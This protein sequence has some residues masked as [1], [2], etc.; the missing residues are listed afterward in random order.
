M[1]VHLLNKKR[2][3]ALLIA[4]CCGWGTAWASYSFS[5]T[6]SGKTLY[7]NIVSGTNVE[8]CYPGTL[9]TS[10]SCGWDGYT[11]PTGAVSIPSTVTNNGTTYSVKY[12]GN[13]AFAGCTGITSVSIPS[14]IICRASDGY[15]NTGMSGKGM[16]FKNCSGLTSITLPNS[17]TFTCLPYQMCSMCT[18]LSSI[19]IPS[20]ITDIGPDCFVNTAL[21]SVTIPSSV[22]TIYG[23]ALTY[24]QNLSSITVQASTPPTLYGYSQFDQNASSLVIYVPCESRDTYR[25]AWSSYSS[26]IQGYG[27]PYTI[28][29]YASPSA[30]GTVT[31]GGGFS[32]GQTCT[33]TASYP[34]TGYNFVN[35]TKSGSVVSTNRTYSFVVYSNGTYVL[36]IDTLQG[37]S[38]LSTPLV[39]FQKYHLSYSLQ[40]R[41]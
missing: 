10:T 31:G 26:K 32:S 36:C 35:W 20:R 2:I 4:L 16:W 27:C 39:C 33:L 13:Y 19:S 21:T 7:F 38:I 18:S 6:V 3:I 30:G 29:A 24:N 23:G 25:S 17:S 12:I 37:T 15:T 9:N 5:A 28:T 34:N 22:T 14:S 8:V 41:N 11:K 1:I 40:N